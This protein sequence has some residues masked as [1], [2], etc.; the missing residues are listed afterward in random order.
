MGNHRNS[1]LE[2]LGMLCDSIVIMS[3][4]CVYKINLMFILYV[5]NPD[6]TL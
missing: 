2:Y 6:T 3:C 4:F 1:L 5:K